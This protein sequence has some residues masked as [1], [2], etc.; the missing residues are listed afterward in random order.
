MTICVAVKVAEGL[1]LAADSTIIV[2]GPIA[3]PNGQQTGII[4]TFEFA[5]KVTRI[6]DYPVGVMRWGIDSINSRS[7]HSLIMEFEHGYKR[8]GE[9]DGYT[10]HQI[11]GDLISF[12]HAR[13]DAA[14]PSGSGK[15]ILGLFVGGFSNKSFFADE[16]KYDFSAD[17]TPIVVRQNTPYGVP[18]FGANW[19]GMTDALVRLFQGYD[20]DALNELVRRGV[21]PQIISQ[22]ITDQVPALKI[23]FDAMPLQ[24]AVD[25]AEYAVQLVIGRFRFGQGLPLCGGDIDIAVITP[26]RFRWSK[27]KKWGIKDDGKI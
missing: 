8:C 18:D 16:F 1:V 7:I 12:I 25:F 14:F 19:Y 11:V 13:Y 4:Q 3:T 22:W 20:V 2:Q 17:S 21:D 15:P 23:V 10:V 24:D 27:I 5:N 6:K 9:N 26:D